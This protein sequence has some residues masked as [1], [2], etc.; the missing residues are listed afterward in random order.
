MPNWREQVPL[1]KERDARIKLTEADK[2][3]VVEFHETGL[4]SQR[5]LAKE[6]GVSRRL[7]T[8]IIDPEK[9][10]E[11]LRRRAEAG[12][13]KKYYDKDK[14][15]ASIKKHRNRKKELI[16]DNEHPQQQEASA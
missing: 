16:G 12:G 1:G 7:I 10:A 2:K 13:S 6:F 4:W 11:N 5:A 14:H 8:F 15:R 9:K 3:R